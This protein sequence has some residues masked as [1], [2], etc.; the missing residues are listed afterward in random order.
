MEKRQNNFWDLDIII[1][2]QVIQLNMAIMILVEWKLGRNFILAVLEQT[3][4]VR[5]KDE[6]TEIIKLAFDNIDTNLSLK[7]ILSYLVFA[8]EF[9]TQDLILDQ[10][11]GESVYIN[12]VWIFKNDEE[13]SN[14]LF[15]NLK[16]LE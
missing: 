15:E 7:Y 4:K 5:S 1:M 12:G 16:F 13:K 10:L 11:P 9:N 3:L 6:I 2:E 14:I 8:M